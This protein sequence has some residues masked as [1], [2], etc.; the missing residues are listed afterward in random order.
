MRVIFAGGGTGGH[1]FPALAVADE[2]RARSPQPEI[3]FIGVERGLEGR[4][5][6]AAGYRLHTIAATGFHGVG[7]NAK[8]RS[9]WLLGRSTVA[10]ERLL[11][12]FDADAVFSVG[13][14]VSAPVMLAAAFSQRPS[15]MFESNAEP[16]LAN[17]ALAPLATRVAVTYEAT[18]RF[19]D[20]NAVRTGSPV[21]R[22]FLR[23][24]PKQHAPPFTL[25]IFGGSQGALGINAAV[26]ESLDILR[27]VPHE[28]RFIHQSGERDFDAV[29]TAYARRGIRADV[30]PF[31]ENMADCF[32]Q[33]DLIVCR[34][35]ASTLAE[36]AAAG[37]AAILVPFP[38]AAGQHQLRNAELLARAGAVRLLEQRELS[39][40]RLAAT[41]LEL[42]EQPERIATME[43]RVRAFAV[44]AAAARLADLIESVAR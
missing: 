21:R 25:L 37:K 41:L 24:P 14:Y 2:L 27:A 8:A 32:A 12:E 19:F 40:A 23:V 33:A 35:G 16:G 9:V 31:I 43:E 20:R 44:P 26:V 36:L 3:A 29:R 22:A 34:A 1:V 5:V 30:R 7:W 4:V 6:P 28:L 13:G 42:L 38:Q 15:V 17:R 11:R 10:C 39:G 18:L